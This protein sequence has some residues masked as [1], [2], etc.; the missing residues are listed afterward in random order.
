MLPVPREE[1]ASGSVCRRLHLCLCGCPA[2]R[3]FE[4][5]EGTSLNGE[6][7]MEQLAAPF[8]ST[9]ASVAAA[10]TAALLP[11]PRSRRLEV[12]ARESSCVTLPRTV[13]KGQLQYQ[14]TT[15]PAVGIVVAASVQTRNSTHGLN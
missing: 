7:E 4:V 3:H 2:A 8:S 1:F 10:A 11:L 9:A 15:T 12:R 5:V 14:H 13:L 6:G